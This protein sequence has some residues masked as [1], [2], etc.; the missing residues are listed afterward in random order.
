[1][2]LGATLWI[3]ATLV[4]AAG[5]L[6]V[7]GGAARQHA[8]LLATAGIAVVVAGPFLTLAAIAVSARRASLAAYAIATI[9][10]ALLGALMAR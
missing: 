4:I 9:T 6:D 1:M 5:G 7:V 10:I 2:L 8:P 3:G